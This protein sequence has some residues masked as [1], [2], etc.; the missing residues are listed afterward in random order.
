MEENKM[1]LV[2]WLDDLCVRFVINLPVEEL[3]SPERICF[4]IEEAQWHYEDFIRPLDPDLPSLNLRAFT[5]KMFAHCPLL[6]DWTEDQ[7]DEA[8][9]AF[10][11]Y[12]Q[13][14]PVRGAIMLN[15]T[16]DDVLMVK[17]W[18]KGASWSFPRG[19]LNQN[20]LDLTCAI[21]EVQE[22]TGYNLKMAGLIG[23]EE[24]MKSIEVEIRGQDLKMYVF[25]GVPMDTHFEPQTRKEISKIEWHKLS[26]LPTLKKQ[27]Q[28]Q[29]QQPSQKSQGEDL[30]KNANKYYMVAPF[31]GS[32]KRW[33]T[34][35]KKQDK[36]VQASQ[37]KTVKHTHDTSVES[38]FH[39]QEDMGERTDVEQAGQQHL[40]RLLDTLRQSSQAKASDLPEV[41]HEATQSGV[42]QTL[43]MPKSADLLALL[44]KEV[45]PVPEQEPHTPFDRMITEPEYPRSPSRHAPLSQ[46]SDLTPPVFPMY[47]PQP[48]LSS[49]D[50]ILQASDPLQ[51]QPQP[52]QLQ[53]IPPPQRPAQLAPRPVRPPIVT[54]ERPALAPYQRTHDNEGRGAAPPFGSR[55][56][57]PPQASKLPTPQLNKHTS[58]LLN[59]FKGSA[60]AS[61]S[62][63]NIDFQKQAEAEDSKE[64]RNPAPLST[65]V[66]P[67]I[68]RQSS[69]KAPRKASQPS[70]HQDK[71]LNMFRRPST[72][73]TASKGLEPP[74]AVVE[75]SASPKPPRLDRMPKPAQIPQEANPPSKDAQLGQVIIQKPPTQ[76]EPPVS[77]TIK[78]PLNTPEFEMIR[79]SH[80]GKD[81]E[82]VA[83]LTKPVKVSP[84]QILSRPGSSHRRGNNSPSRMSLR[85]KPNPPKEAR[86]GNT[87]ET[88]IKHDL[89]PPRNMGPRT[90]TLA[91]NSQPSTP[92]L[93]ARDDPQKPFQPQILRRPDTSHSIN[94]PSPIQ[95][96]PS[97]QHQIPKPQH[98]AQSH[99][100]KKSLLSLFTRPQPAVSPPSAAPTDISSIVSPIDDATTPT[101]PKATRQARDV[102]T[103]QSSV[104][105]T[106]KSPPSVI[107]Q[108]E[109]SKQGKKF[110][111]PDRMPASP[112]QSSTLDGK[113]AN[114]IVSERESRKASPSKVQ[115][116]S[117]TPVQKDF[118]LGYLNDVVKGGDEGWDL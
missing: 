113:I 23:E 31:L 20:E 3:E 55:Q 52:H 47:P 101:A 11:E 105:S 84:I 116:A 36:V 6:C 54:T 95:P 71:L 16:M 37:A 104:V 67:Q 63:A 39:E 118:L 85:H 79:S 46:T 111:A 2:D 66:P 69:N 99:E 58:S 30:A 83:G 17:G 94:E 97:P 61:S 65:F 81:N 76:D 15:D 106:I 78:G 92:N 41:T 59:L 103:S 5:K 112:I 108:R 115:S 98:T 8:F 22:E 33:I 10:L 109:K 57:F 68:S 86:S 96:L 100:H 89:L 28:Q 91:K 38:P 102:S 42:D 62:Q 56:S 51:P 64:R 49:H 74:P 90:T 13:T 70:A 87:P 27:K 7:Q 114:G 73:K 48:I 34:Q 40:T 93:K 43:A 29:A 35:Q 18:K 26:G 25:R 117:T 12:K 9:K 72:P 53:P 82:L 24:D 107:M 32:L 45:D 75:L 88:P 110:Y 60:P 77:A 44:R 50:P 19:K 1:Q 14:V 80:L 4:Q 21:R